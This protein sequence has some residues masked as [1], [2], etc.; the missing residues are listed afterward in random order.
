MYKDY[1]DQE[2]I[3]LIAES[4][5]SASNIL[6]KKYEG[7]ISL[8]AKKY[9]NLAKRYGLEYNDMFQEG[10]V[11]LSEAIRCY[12]EQKDTKFSSF[13][14]LCIDRQIY[15]ALSKASR[16]KH[17][18]LNES[19]SLDLTIEDDGKPLIDF[20]F[21]KDSDPSIK[22][23]NEENRKNLMEYLNN[24][25]TGL[26]KNV[27]NLRLN[28]FEYKEI[29]LLLNKSYKSIDSSLQRVRIK[30]KEYMKKNQK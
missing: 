21:D 9:L 1:D 19:F 7:L 15:S 12:K 6:Y 17:T 29:S 16:K 24:N 22:L 13:A 27:L 30:L 8:K 4:N 3:Y 18:L 2:L 25:L 11:G 10:M 20:L 26:E 28:G 23:E 14:N 5:E